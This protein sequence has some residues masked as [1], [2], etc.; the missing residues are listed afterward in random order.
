MPHN[1]IRKEHKD[2]P[3]YIWMKWDINRR[4]MVDW[5]IWYSSGITRHE[6]TSVK[7]NENKMLQFEL[8]VSFHYLIH[9]N[10]YGVNHHCKLWKMF[11]I[12]LQL[13]LVGI[14]KNLT[15]LPKKQKNHCNPTYSM[16]TILWV[17][18]NLTPHF[19][20]PAVQITHQ[21]VYLHQDVSYNKWC[22]YSIKHISVSKPALSPAACFSF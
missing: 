4:W 17:M 14:M 16:Y 22:H 6:Y 19:S 18:R 3:T 15:A 10:F 11:R 20:K 2:W 8:H 21:T 1:L 9:R 5:F 12:Y 7:V 13:T